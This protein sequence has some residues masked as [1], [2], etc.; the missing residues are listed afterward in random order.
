MTDADNPIDLAADRLGPPEAV[1]HVSARRF[2]TKLAVG[3]GLL[4]YGIV[5][6]YL[7]WVP[8][9]ARFDHLAL[10]IL[11]APPI[12]GISL[13]WHV[14][15][16]RGLHVLVYPTGLLRFHRGELES[17]PWSEIEEVRIRA[18]AA[19]IEV[20]HDEATGQ[21]RSCWLEVETPIFQIWKVGTTLRRTDGT[22]VTLT[23]ALEDYSGLAER[24]MRSTFAE[25]W[26]D[27]WARFRDGE[28][29]RFGDFSVSLAGIGFKDKQSL[30]W[31]D[32]R[33][34]LISQK[35]VSLKRVNGWV[36]WAVRELH[37]VPNP[38]LLVALIAV[39][40]EE[41]VGRDDTESDE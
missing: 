40:R 5:A 13:L 29:I 25:H 16:T 22:T 30:P 12:S 39:A 33:E 20:D 3:L 4:L 37:E 31:S 19:S 35:C 7:W 28:T 36:P 41:S 38:H 26:P 8:G 23:P 18:D 11:F 21:L 6:N 9:P 32:L 17:Y 10:A 27:M 34:V 15:Q 24:L 2:G 1:H 14:L